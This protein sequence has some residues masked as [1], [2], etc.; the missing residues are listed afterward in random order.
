MKSEGRD[1]TLRLFVACELPAEMKATLASL[2]EALRR[3][4]APP[5]RWVR[6][7]GIH[8]TLKFLGAVPQDRVTAICQA[9]TPAVEGIPLLSLQLAEVGTF[10]DRRGPRVLWVGIQG[11]IEPLTRLQERVKKA[12]APLG[13]P[14]EGRAFS[15]HLTLARVPDYMG[16]AERQALRELAKETPLPTA[17]AATIRELSLMRSIL[18]PG[19]AVYERLAAFPFGES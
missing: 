15:P 17:P 11:D 8:L 18:G 1:S 6:P 10:A 5:V 19:G 9:L 2:Q 3:K 4:E 16:R 12:L 14:P 7:E 13:F